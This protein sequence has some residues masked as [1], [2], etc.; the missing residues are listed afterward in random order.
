MANDPRPNSPL[1]DPGPITRLRGLVP[2]RAA[3]PASG[4]LLNLMESH[5]TMGRP[6]LRAERHETAFSNRIGRPPSGNSATE[7][8]DLEH[9][10]DPPLPAGTSNRTTIGVEFEFLVAV[11]LRDAAAIDPHPNDGRSLSTALVSENEASAAFRLSV[12]N[13]LI[14]TLRRNGIV[15]VKSSELVHLPGVYASGLN[16]WDSLED[17][18]RLVDPNLTQLRTWIGQAAWNPALSPQD[19]VEAAANA[20]AEQFHQFHANNGLAIHQTLNSTCEMIARTRATYFLNGFPNEAHGP[21]Y[22]RLEIRLKEVITQGKREHQ[23]VINS[24]VDPNAVILPGLDQKYFHWSCVTDVSV[25]IDGVEPEHYSFPDGTT[26]PDPGAIY[27]WFSAEVR[28]PPLDYDHP[29]TH[30]I[31]QNACGSLRNFYR[32]H[33]PTS[34]IES[35]LHVHFGQ[36]AGWTLLHLKKLA[37]LWI[38]LEQSLETLHRQDR[39]TDNPFT[40]ALRRA[41]PIA[42][43]LQHGDFSA[44]ILSGLS[45]RDPVRSR[46]QNN[47]MQRYVPLAESAAYISDYLQNFINEI[48]QYESITALAR[49]LSGTRSGHVQ[50]RVRGAGRSDPLAPQGLTQTLEVRIMQ[51]TLDAN[52]IWSW[53]SLVERMIVFSRDAHPI[54][55]KRGLSD[56]LSGTRLPREVI[57][58][59]P[60]DMLYFTQRQNQETGFF[61]YPDHDKVDWLAP[62][63]I[64]GYANTHGVPTV[65]YT[66]GHASIN[67][68]AATNGYADTNGH[69]APY[70][71]GNGH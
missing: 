56:M 60:G 10:E 52:H 15:A 63:M 55:F 27:K 26:P 33:K 35:G 32:I 12:R 29:D 68:H 5:A 59:E 49:G 51:G 62:F 64:P 22:Q 6:L 31:L 57:G 50:W 17:P 37:T 66:N 69:A 41:S 44:I 3:P 39:S 53:I 28:S 38:L 47:S 43:A 67:G 23:N 70:M 19:N 20:L 45:T 2:H 1:T 16:Y 71:N 61:E 36:E 54:D 48:W 30:S 7:P 9:A 40:L 11:T 13:S 42:D 8:M 25:S 21:T 14:D 24:Q 4:N 58:I 46:L 65:P 18:Q 34:H